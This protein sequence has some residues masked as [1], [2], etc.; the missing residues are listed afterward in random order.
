M[1][2]GYR[3][4]AEWIADDYRKNAA[5]KVKEIYLFPDPEEKEIRLVET[6]PN[7]IP[8]I[9][10]GITPYYFSSHAPFNSPFTLAV[11]II[12]PEEKQRLTLPGKWGGWGDAVRLFPKKQNKVRRNA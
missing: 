11:A 5:N 9:D 8:T 7:A 12:R 6:V 3:E 1:A 4:K 2:T 10:E